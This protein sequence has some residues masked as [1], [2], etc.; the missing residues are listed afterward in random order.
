[1][2]ARLDIPYAPPDPEDGLGHLLDLYLPDGA[3]GPVP[4]I[5]WSSG[6]GWMRD[7]GKHGAA[8]VSTYFNA[9]GY[10]VAGIS[11]RSSGQ[12]TFPA[13]LHDAKAA[14]RWLRST[15][16]EHG[17]D[18]DRFVSMG[19][20]SGGWVA[21]MLALTAD[22]PELEGEVGVGGVSSR[23]QAAVAFY[24]PTDFLQMDAHMIQDCVPFMSFLG[25][26][27]C[28]DDPGS[29]ESR[30][31]GGPIETRPDECAR[32]NPVNYVGAST[33]PMLLVHGRVDPF[34]PHHQSE[35][36]Y[37]ALAAHGREMGHERPYVTD[38]GR[39]GAYAVRESRG[40]R[41]AP[42]EGAP[43]PTWQAVEGFVR[44]AFG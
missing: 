12:A 32:A 34:V 22:R 42:V 5:V 19:D 4:L 33:P 44:G 8:E 23:V 3:D 13:Q 14:V 15:A 11:V 31:V 39:A 38:P 26:E 28:H 7:D 41:D 1:V 30:L 21:T 29:P 27:G 43:P 37:A 6:S 20:S 40:G 25:I 18:P 2:T 16:G 24:G 35:L 9:A 36:L 10:A 17:L